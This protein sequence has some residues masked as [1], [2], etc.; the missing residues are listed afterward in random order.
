L[1]DKIIIP[2]YV[3]NSI[4]FDM[5]SLK[6]ANECYIN[7]FK[8]TLFQYTKSNG[9]LLTDLVN[10]ESVSKFTTPAWATNAELLEY[11]NLTP[12]LK[13]LTIFSN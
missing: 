12:K 7:S 13:K 10:M 4:L 1:N 9:Y 5:R 8:K 11:T 3:F 2:S 6:N